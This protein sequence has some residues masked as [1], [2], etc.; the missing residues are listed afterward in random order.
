M[1]YGL[2]ASSCDPLMPYIL[3]TILLYM[4]RKKKPFIASPTD[5]DFQ[6]FFFLLK[7]M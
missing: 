2:K 6:G 1:A 7:I 3:L 5:P 4:Q